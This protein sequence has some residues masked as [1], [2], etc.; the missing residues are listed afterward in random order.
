MGIFIIKNTLHY[1]DYQI[2]RELTYHFMQQTAV[3][4]SKEHT[5]IQDFGNV[6]QEVLIDD[7][8]KH[9]RGEEVLLKKES[10][11]RTRKYIL[12]DQRSEPIALYYIALY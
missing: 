5:Q 3:A 10:N 9:S 8:S 2:Y 12:E 11:T 1:T 6:K 7:F 4:L